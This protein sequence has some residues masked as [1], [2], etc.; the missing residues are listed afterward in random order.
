MDSNFVPIT[1][2][3][4]GTPEFESRVSQMAKRIVYNLSIAASAEGV[5]T[6]EYFSRAAKSLLARAEN[7]TFFQS[8]EARFSA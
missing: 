6:K 4:P 5:T 1:E 7:E 2:L 8:L 3:Q